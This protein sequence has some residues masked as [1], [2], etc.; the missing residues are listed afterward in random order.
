MKYEF[1]RIAD[2]SE[3]ELNALGAQGFHVVCCSTEYEQDSASRREPH[4]VVYLQ[5]EVPEGTAEGFSTEH[6]FREG[7]R[8]GFLTWIEMQSES[9]A[10][11]IFGPQS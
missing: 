1:R 6:A 9:S 3:K 8:D 7:I 11:K 2:P 5:R 4:P 10:R